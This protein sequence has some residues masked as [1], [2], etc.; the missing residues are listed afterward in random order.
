MRREKLKG[1]RKITNRWD[2]DEWLGGSVLNVELIIL[3]LINGFCLIFLSFLIRAK[4][5]C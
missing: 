4:Q 3:L 2:D 1:K 5:N